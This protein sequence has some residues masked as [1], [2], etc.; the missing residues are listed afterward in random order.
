[1]LLAVIYGLF[2]T[3]QFGASQLETPGSDNSSC[4]T[5][6]SLQVQQQFNHTS[7]AMAPLGRSSSGL[8]IRCKKCW[9]ND[10]RRCQ[11]ECG[12]RLGY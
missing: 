7:D 10:S 3:V 1:M 9:Y 4:Q 8:W 2:L 6:G 5:D 12:S 11:C